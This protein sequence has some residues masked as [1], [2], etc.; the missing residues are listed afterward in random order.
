MSLFLTNGAKVSIG[1]VKRFTGTDWAASDFT[2]VTWKEIKETMSLGSVGDTAELVTVKT[3]GRPR[4]GKLK[5]TVNAGS[6]EL[7]AVTDYADEGQLAVRSA[8]TDDED[9]A[10]KIEFSDKPAGGTNSIRYFT[11]LV[12]SAQDQVDEADNVLKLVATLEID[13]NVVVVHAAPAGP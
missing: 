2:S 9:Y 10:F 13:S 12:M 3:L 5:G 7:S 6:V 4:V 8:A 1:P 11:A